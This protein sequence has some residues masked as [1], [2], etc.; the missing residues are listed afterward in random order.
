MRPFGCL[1]FLLSLTTSSF[2]SEITPEN[3]GSECQTPMAKKILTPRYP[4]EALRDGIG[5]KVVVVAWIDRCGRVVKSEIIKSSGNKLL[6]A[7]AL[8]AANNSIF[9]PEENSEQ[10]LFRLELPYGFTADSELRL[11]KAVWPASHKKAYFILDEQ[12]KSFASVQAAFDSVAG[13]P[14]RLISKQSMLDMRQLKNKNGDVW[15]FLSDS[16]TYKFKIAALYQR[17]QAEKPTVSV[18]VF[19]DQSIKD[20]DLIKDQLLK[21]GLQPFAKSLNQ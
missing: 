18:Q 19:C 8:E 20:C 5:G 1:I 13:Q 11:E 17:I 10:Q 15:L 6:N 9:R 2:A 4:A 7:A 14:H 12:S 16:S 3:A 21:S